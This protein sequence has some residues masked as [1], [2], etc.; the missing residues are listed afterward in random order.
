MLDA[1][2]QTQLKAYLEKLV[3]PIELIASLDGSPKA[4]E[5]RTLLNDIAALSDKVSVSENGTAQLRPSF[6]VARAGEAARVSLPVSRWGTSFPHWC[7][8]CCR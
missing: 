1:A 6:G 3:N 7:W 4:A 2:I 8:R 5:I